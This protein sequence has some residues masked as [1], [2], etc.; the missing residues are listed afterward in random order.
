MRP[1]ARLISAISSRLRNLSD[2]ALVSIFTGHVLGTVGP[3]PAW[4]VF[5]PGLSIPGPEAR[6]ESAGTPKKHIHLPWLEF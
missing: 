1:L 6:D 3:V 4:R 2:T 5:T